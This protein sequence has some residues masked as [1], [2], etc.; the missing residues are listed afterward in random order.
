MCHRVALGELP[1]SIPLWVLLSKPATQFFLNLPA[2]RPEKR[3][4]YCCPARTLSFLPVPA[5][6]VLNQTVYNSH[7]DTGQVR[8]S[9]APR[10]C[11]AECKTLFCRN[12]KS[13]PISTASFLPFAWPSEKRCREH[14]RRYIFSDA[15]CA[16]QGFIYFLSRRTSGGP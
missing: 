11:F 15:I 12:G 1:V 8:A 14:R 5:G 3:R 16:R 2:F 9:G 13:V 4:E 6:F 10:F 7:I